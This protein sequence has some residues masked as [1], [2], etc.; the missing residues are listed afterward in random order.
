MTPS[1]LLVQKSCD[2]CSL[3]P[4]YPRDQDDNGNRHRY[5]PEDPELGQESEPPLTAVEIY[6]W[7]HDCLN[8]QLLNFDYK[9]DL[10][11]MLTA[12]AVA[13]RKTIVSN[14]MLFIADESRFV[15]FATCCCIRLYNCIRETSDPF[16]ARGFINYSKE[17]KTFFDPV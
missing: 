14:E 9:V 5:S 8:G 1:G 2:F 13:G 4:N 16:V 15:S 17:G 3:Y 12:I 10:R 7:S 11:V 6:E